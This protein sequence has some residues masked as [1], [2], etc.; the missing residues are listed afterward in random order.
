M[1]TDHTDDPSIP[2]QERLF[3]RINLLHMVEGDAGRSR[4]SSAA[5]RERELSIT[6]ESVM[7]AAGK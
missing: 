6:L 5:F 2:S 1:A 3:R 7:S 4:T